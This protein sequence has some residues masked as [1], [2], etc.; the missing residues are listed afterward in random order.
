MENTLYST[1]KYS[2]VRPVHTHSTS[3]KERI[4]NISVS[5]LNIY[6]INIVNLCC[7]D[8]S[9]SRM[10]GCTSGSLVQLPVDA[11]MFLFTRMSRYSGVQLG[12]YSVAA[13][14]FCLEV[15][16][17]W[18]FNSSSA[19]QEIPPNFVESK[20]SLPYHKSLLLCPSLKLNESSPAHH[21]LFL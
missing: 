15:K 17:P 10:L 18:G 14:G 8:S 21:I 3:V 1:N 20:C 16:C 4:L 5:V 6:I 12:S 11:E 7:V 2:C 9:V 19:S 13:R